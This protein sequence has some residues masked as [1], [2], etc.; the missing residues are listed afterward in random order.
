MVSTG[1]GSADCLALAAEGAHL[2]AADI[3]LAAAEALLVRAAAA[4]ADGYVPK[5]AFL[6]RWV[7]AQIESQRS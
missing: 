6:S 4:G 5:D 7:L 3:D 1:L 2:W